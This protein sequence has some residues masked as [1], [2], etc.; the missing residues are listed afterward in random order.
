[1]VAHLP[2]APTFEF[3]MT[4]YAENELSRVSM[5]MDF[6]KITYRV[7]ENVRPIIED[8]IQQVKTIFG[9]GRVVL[10]VVTMEAEKILFGELEGSEKLR[11]YSIP[12]H[13]IFGRNGMVLLDSTKV[14]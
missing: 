8:I 2:L 14:C 5:A 11:P 1:M 10:S 13:A 6:M 12:S 4:P 9:V 7:K 3:M